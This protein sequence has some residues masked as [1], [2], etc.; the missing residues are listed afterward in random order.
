MQRRP[1]LSTT[2]NQELD[3]TDVQRRRA[4]RRCHRRRLRAHVED[5]QVQHAGPG[6]VASGN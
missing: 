5:R 3:K 6:H 2:K 4:R 1:L